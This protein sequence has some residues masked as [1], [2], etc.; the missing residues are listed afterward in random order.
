MPKMACRGAHCGQRGSLLSGCGLHEARI[1]V[2]GCRLLRVR[3]DAARGACS[4]SGPMHRP[5]RW[6]VTG[7]TN[8]CSKRSTRHLQA[9]SADL[10]EPT[11][12]HSRYRR[13]HVPA[14]R[15]GPLRG[16]GRDSRFSR[17]AASAGKSSLGSRRD[18]PRSY[19]GL[20]MSPS[21]GF[22]NRASVNTTWTPSHLRCFPQKKNRK[23]ETSTESTDQ[24]RYVQSKIF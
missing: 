3:G 19:P 17:D 2:A 20:I 6:R 8:T 5:G 4:A 15:P 12:K 7:S 21:A 10:A 14:S 9:S 18:G 11:W 23:F 22:G 13:P 24:K 1:S 16:P